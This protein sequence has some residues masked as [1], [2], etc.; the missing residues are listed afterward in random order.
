MPVGS[1]HLKSLWAS[2]VDRKSDLGTHLYR[3]RLPALSNPACGKPVQNPGITGI[4]FP[5]SYCKAD[6][7]CPCQ[8]SSG[9]PQGACVI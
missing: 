1:Y 9:Q 8:S 4:G 2:S 7:L 6:V 5:S 3:L